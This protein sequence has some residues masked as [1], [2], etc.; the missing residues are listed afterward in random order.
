MTDL[1]GVDS[2]VALGTS[3]EEA[4]SGGEGGGG[5]GGQETPLFHLTTQ[6]QDMATSGQLDASAL[7]RLARSIDPRTVAGLKDEFDQMPPNVMMMMQF[8]KMHNYARLRHCLIHP[9]LTQDV[10][11]QFHAHLAKAASLAEQ[12][13]AST[14]VIAK[15]MDYPAEFDTLLA[16]AQL[17]RAKKPKSKKAQRLRDRRE[18]LRKKRMQATR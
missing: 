12:V 11:I 5:G 6:I 10:L 7:V 16:E 17:A 1:F 8:L 13:T 3:V 2:N 18:K 4:P 9:A 14:M 15:C